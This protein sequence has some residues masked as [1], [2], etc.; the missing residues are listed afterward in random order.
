MTEIL[1]Y[2]HR[3]RVT[4]LAWSADGSR[5]FSTSFDGSIKVWQREKI[6]TIREGPVPDETTRAPKEAIW[7]MGRLA[8]QDEFI[9]AEQ[10]R[11]VHYSSGYVAKLIGEGI[12]AVEL[13]CSPTNALV[14]LREIVL[15]DG[16]KQVQPRLRVR[17]LKRLAD[18]PILDTD[19]FYDSDWWS[20]DIAWAPNGELLAALSGGVISVWLVGLYATRLH[21]LPVGRWA[22]AIAWLNNDELVVVYGDG[23]IRI[24]DRQEL[25]NDKYRPRSKTVLE[26]HEAFVTAISVGMG[27]AQFATADTDNCICIWDKSLQLVSKTAVD[28]LD[29]MSGLTICFN[30][31]L[32]ILACAQG[33]QISLVHLENESQARTVPADTI[34]APTSSLDKLLHAAG[35]LGYGEL[36]SDQ[37]AELWQVQAN[38]QTAGE[39]LEFTKQFRRIARTTERLDLLLCDTIRRALVAPTREEAIAVE[40][41]ELDAL[42]TRDRETIRGKISLLLAE[43]ANDENTGRR[44]A[45]ICAYA[46]FSVRG[47]SQGFRLSAADQRNFVSWTNTLEDPELRRRLKH[48]SA[49]EPVR[50]VE[51]IAE[52]VELALTTVVAGL[53]EATASPHQEVAEDRDP[54]KAVI[55]ISASLERAK[56]QPQKREASDADAS[57]RMIEK[58]NYQPGTMQTGE[59]SSLASGTDS[60]SAQ[61]MKHVVI[62]VHGIRDYALWQDSVRKTFENAGFKSE[63]TNYGRFNLIEFLLPFSYFRTK[64]IDIV[65]RQIRII[66]Q[67]NEGALLSV[68]AHS[69]GTYVIARLM[70]ETFDVK[71]HRVI[72]CGSVVRYGFPF[73]DFQNRFGEPILNEVGTRDVWPAIAE[74][75]TIGYGSAGTYGFKRPLVKDR[76]HNNARHGYFLNAEFCKRYWVPWL[77]RGIFVAGAEKAQSPS[78]WI[79]ILS[80]VKIKYVL[81]V[82]LLFFTATFA[83]HKFETYLH[84]SKLMERPAKS[85]RTTASHPNLKVSALINEDRFCEV[86]G[87]VEGKCTAP[88]AT[89]FAL[90]IENESE[91]AIGNVV[92]NIKL[93]GIERADPNSLAQALHSGEF[94]PL[95]A[96]GFNSP[97]LQVTQSFYGGDLSY[98]FSIPAIAAHQR[99]MYRIWRAKDALLYFDISVASENDAISKRVL[100]DYEGRKH[101]ECKDSIINLAT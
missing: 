43:I 14:A 68:V 84:D 48:L 97:S 83:R 66:K 92:V 51:Q 29:A 75:V 44:T 62:L 23:N 45:A 15:P 12:S 91:S 39:A 59:L 70:Q 61:P 56:E 88:L 18:P 96:F 72:F 94:A 5:L 28:R 42:R 77:Q 8:G 76:W 21:G 4:G 25:G 99:A 9:A 37:M 93:G 50:G 7:S 32:S 19:I 17:D 33:H 86:S 78:R 63:S 54:E 22:N 47:P 74:S 85:S 3:G 11:I 81:L 90:L 27:G 31:N 35:L 82:V 24:F 20:Y 73:E 65:W 41:I 64:A 34:N 100:C 52:S 40:D 98:Q 58:A 87:M 60:S 79:Q 30:P 6:D 80:I 13:K 46:L 36:T 38:H 49:S 16:G 26:A 67:N 69:F 55:A 95:D 71:F 10:A 53:K 2:E 89:S 57:E 1:S 101:G